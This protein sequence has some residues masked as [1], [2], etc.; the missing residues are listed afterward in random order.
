MFLSVESRLYKIFLVWVQKYI[1]EE[2]GTIC[3]HGNVDDLLE[4]L[5][6]KVYENVID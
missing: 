3:A 4:S 1:G 6:R 5:S 2:R